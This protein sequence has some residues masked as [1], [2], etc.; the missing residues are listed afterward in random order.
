MSQQQ[1]FNDPIR[2][3]QDGHYF[4]DNREKSFLWLGDTAWPLFAE[5]TPE[6]ARRYLQSRAATL[7]ILKTW[8]IWSN[9]RL[10]ITLPATKLGASSR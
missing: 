10:A 2:V 3:S 9:W 8:M 5:Y 4:T 6:Q 7:L 1:P